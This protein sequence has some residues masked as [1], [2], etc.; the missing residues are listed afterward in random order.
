MLLIMDSNQHA[1]ITDFSKINDNNKHSFLFLTKYIIELQTQNKFNLLNIQ[2]GHYENIFNNYP[3]IEF[4]P[5]N[6]YII[7]QLYKHY[8]L[9]LEIKKCISKT[10][11]IK[12]LNST[13]NKY[14]VNKEEKDYF[15]RFINIIVIVNLIKKQLKNKSYQDIINYNLL[16]KLNDIN[17]NI[18]SLLNLHQL[19]N[20]VTQEQIMKFFSNIYNY[21]N[22][23]IISLINN[24]NEDEFEKIY[25]IFLL[26]K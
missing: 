6:Y 15:R 21:Q 14:F 11:K 10:T 2:Q 20:L 1:I 24:I 16:N 23:N 4:N 17:P 3:S 13:L 18:I 8:E 26:F 9:F 12:T 25:D 19:F 22:I 7:T 5:N